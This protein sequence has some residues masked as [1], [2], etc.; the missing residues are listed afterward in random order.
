MPRQAQLVV[1]ADHFSWLWIISKGRTN[2]V[3]RL[4]DVD[5][6]NNSYEVFEYDEG[7]EKAYIHHIS[8]ASATL[9]Q[10]KRLQNDDPRNGY[11][12][13]RDMVHMANIPVGVIYIWM[14]KYGVN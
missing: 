10:N 1:L 6:D 2:A 4:F 8:D 9:E 12:D 7:E 5:H 14:T 3:K 11:N 13:A